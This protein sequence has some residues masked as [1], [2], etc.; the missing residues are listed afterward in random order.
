MLYHGRFDFFFFY[1]GCVVIHWAYSVFEF[2][3][4]ERKTIFFVGS[5][6]VVWLFCLML[7]V[8]VTLNLRFI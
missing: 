6:L 5:K 1:S 8:D 3:W 7:C 2:I 4:C